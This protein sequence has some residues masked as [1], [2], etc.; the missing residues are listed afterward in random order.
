MARKPIMICTGFIEDALKG[1]SE[2]DPVYLTVWD[3]ETYGIRQKQE[4]DS[5][6]VRVVSN[7]EMPVSYRSVSGLKI[8]AESFNKRNQCHVLVLDTIFEA[9]RRVPGK[10]PTKSYY[11]ESEEN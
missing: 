4:K 11:I 1:V 2:K 8:L 3:N 7:I 9:P 6:Q 10:I 5:G